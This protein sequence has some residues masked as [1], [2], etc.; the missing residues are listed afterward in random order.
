VKRMHGGSSSD[1]ENVPNISCPGGQQTIEKLGEQTLNTAGN[2][3]P[4]ARR[5]NWRRFQLPH[6][7][8]RQSPSQP[9]PR[10]THTTTQPLLPTTGQHKLLIVLDNV[11]T[12]LKVR[13]FCRFSAES[14]ILEARA[15]LGMV[16]WDVKMD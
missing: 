13:K 8:F 9:K 15:V 14:K 12:C 1:I 11:K 16:R 10:R 6:L 2:K 3:S 5:P 4:G 7:S